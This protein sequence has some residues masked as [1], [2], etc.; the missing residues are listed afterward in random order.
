MFVPQMP[1]F[2]GNLGNYLDEHI[3]Y[4][5]SARQ[6]G[7]EGTVNVSFVIDQVGAISEVT[8]LTGVSPDIDSEAVRL[9]RTMPPWNPGMKNGK[10]VKV[11][12][13][14][15]IYIGPNTSHNNPG[16]VS[17][18]P[19][20]TSFVLR[21]G[22]YI[23]PYIGYGL[24]G[25]QSSTLTP[26]SSGGNIKFGIGLTHIFPS[27]IGIS[28]GLQMQQYKFSYNYSNVPSSG[29]YTVVN[30]VTRSTNSDST[31]IAGYGSNMTYT[32][33]YAQFPILCK[34][35]SSQ[36]NLVGF[37]AEGGVIINYLIGSQVT[38]TAS[39]TQYQLTQQANTDWYSYNSTSVSSATVSSSS[40]SPNKLTVAL[41]LSAG[42]LIP[43][44]TK[45]SLIFAI[46][47]DFGI[48]N[49]GNGSNDAVN[50][51]SS[52]FYYFGSGSYGSFNSYLFDAKLLIKLSGSS[53]SV[54]R[55]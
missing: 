20:D 32:F 55:Y 11:Q 8:V 14:L 53:R 39:Q 41:H 1:T 45:I 23:D 36:E 15:Q 33:T 37:Y 28:V 3:Q 10:A 7:I 16:P 51:G 25:P 26:I 40:Q 48:M 29:D 19:S 27:N 9:V 31:F 47:P 4:P 2:P 35:I 42:V 49:A 18:I 52:K 6:R 21:D 44:S 5:E 22:W 24:G 54:H 38:G 30:T 50:I 43:C 17:Y 34:Y 12:F 13:N 46:S